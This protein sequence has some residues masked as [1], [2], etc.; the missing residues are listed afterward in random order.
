MGNARDIALK[1]AFAEHLFYNMHVLSRLFKNT[2]YIFF[3][4]SVSLILHIHSQLTWHIARGLKSLWALT[5]SKYAM[6]SRVTHSTFK[7]LHKCQPTY[8]GSSLQ[9]TVLCEQRLVCYKYKQ[10]KS[11]HILDSQ[12]CMCPLHSP[13]LVGLTPCNVLEGAVS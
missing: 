7:K 10:W 4:F 8:H 13:S 11:D 3:H 9:S 6:H 1:I 2:M 12:L 5:I